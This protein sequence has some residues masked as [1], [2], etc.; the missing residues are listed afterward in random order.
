M[1]EDSGYALE[2]FREGAE[3]TIAHRLMTAAGELQWRKVTRHVTC[4]HRPRGARPALTDRR[5][6]EGR[7]TQRTD[8]N[9]FK[10]EGVAGR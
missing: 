10:V 7:H 2:P 1:S 4:S 3:F 9:H 8:S 6:G 5:A